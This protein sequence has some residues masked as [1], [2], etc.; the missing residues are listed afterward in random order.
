MPDVNPSMMSV[1]EPIGAGHNSLV[2]LDPEK[3]GPTVTTLAQL[4][5][6]KRRLEADA[7]AADTK[8]KTLQVVLNQA[9]GDAPVAV[10]GHAV[11]TVKTMAASPAALTLPNGIRVMWTEVSDV[12]IN[13]EFVPTVGAKLY[14]G[15]EG[16]AGIEVAGKVE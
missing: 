4:K 13:Q 10:C 2:Q 9:M 15:R 3:Y 11:L 7:R 1:V 16:S 5:I 14:G 6:L 8:I 12:V